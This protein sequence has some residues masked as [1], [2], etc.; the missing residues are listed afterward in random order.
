MPVKPRQRK[1]RIVG[2]AIFL[3]TMSAREHA[4]EHVSHFGEA[5]NAGCAAG[6]QDR[7]RPLLYTR[8]MEQ[9]GSGVM[10]LGRKARPR[11]RDTKRQ[12]IA[13]HAGELFLSCVSQ[14]N[15]KDGGPAFRFAAQ[16]SRYNGGHIS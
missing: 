13:N 8:Q 15:A 11:K 5:D 1:S 3:R 2:G 6:F 9:I 12:P 16:A 14:T 7:V 4:L 10:I